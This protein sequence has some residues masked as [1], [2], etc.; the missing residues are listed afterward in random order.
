MLDLDENLGPVESQ[1][2]P[3]ENAEGGDSER[4][5]EF[6]GFFDGTSREILC[7]ST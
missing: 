2:F 5:E 6:N 4:K 1:S 7:K 3:P